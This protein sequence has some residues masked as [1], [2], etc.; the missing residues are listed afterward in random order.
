MAAPG[1]QLQIEVEDDTKAE[2]VES[3]TIDHLSDLGD[4]VK[5][6]VEDF[7]RLNQGAVIPP[8]CIRVKQADQP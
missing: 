5:E 3:I 7:V 8:V 1:K 6:V 4:G 2:L